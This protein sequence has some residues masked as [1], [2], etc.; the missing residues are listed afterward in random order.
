VQRVFW[1]VAEGA[2]AATLL[3]AG[4]LDA[5]QTASITT[6]LPFACVLLVAC[7]GLVKGLRAEGLTDRPTQHLAPDVTRH[8][9]MSPS[10][11]SAEPEAAQPEEATTG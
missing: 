7:V 9:D 5:L 2:V 11:A 1:A 10:A 6:A 3:V 4:G 8:P